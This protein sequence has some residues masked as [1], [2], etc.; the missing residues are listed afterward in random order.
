MTNFIQLKTMPG[1]VM[2]LFNLR[3]ICQIE[4]SVSTL[5]MCIV[6]L[7]TVKKF[8]CDINFMEL[9]GLLQPL[10]RKYSENVDNVVGND[11]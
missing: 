10:G 8:V 5:N 1:S 2:T 4:P 6:T 7:V 3:H 9:I 11:V